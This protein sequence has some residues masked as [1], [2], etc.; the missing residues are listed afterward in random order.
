MNWKQAIFGKPKSEQR[1]LP[2][3]TMS[4]GRVLSWAGLGDLGALNLSIFYRGTQLISTSISQLPIYTK[5][6]TGKGSSNILKNHPTNLLWDN[7][8]N[9][10]DRV[11]ML[12][13]IVQSVILKGN[14][15]A[16]I[17]RGDDG[18]PLSLRYL[19]SSDVTINYVKER[20]FL[21]Y[22]CSYIQNGKNISPADM[23]HF[24]LFSFD[25]IRGVS[26]L[27]YSVQSVD[28]ANSTNQHAKD[29]FSSGTNKTSGVLTVNA[30]VNEKQRLQILNTWEETYSNGKSGLA[31]LQGNMKYEPISV[32][33][34]AAQMLESREFNQADIAQWLNLNPAQLGLKGFQN[35]NNFEDS[36]S[37][38]LQRTLMPYISMIENELTRKLVPNEKN[39]K[40][41]L[42]TVGYLRPNKKAQADY[43]TALVSG[44]IL[45]IN[46]ARMELGYPA[47]DGGETPIIPYTD[48]NQNKVSNQKQEDKK[49]EQNGDKD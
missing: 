30:Q 40:I 17:E 43:Y 28:T 22:N 41:V 24:K 8:T 38:L 7:P 31:V 21:C 33:A 15:Y 13:S 25:G 27:K 44:G 47:I 49:Q 39:V 2:E 20:N 45:S 35:F 5:K 6:I 37:E 11:T 42:D 23:L 1:A 46:E 3:Q 19:P 32:D 14:S 10:V 36:Q 26:L 9:L 18:T 34:D 4:S 12:R 48:I 29:F 16:Y